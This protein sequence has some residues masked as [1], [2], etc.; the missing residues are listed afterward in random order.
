[1]LTCRGQPLGV[2]TLGRWSLGRLLW[3]EKG[4][5]GG[6]G[7][8]GREGKGGGG[9][10]GAVVWDCCSDFLLSVVVAVSCCYVPAVTAWRELF[11]A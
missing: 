10:G 3:G 2:H 7:K 11:W 1:V 5:G 6:R 9:G 8:G 4:R